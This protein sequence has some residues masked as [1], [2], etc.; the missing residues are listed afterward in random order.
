MSEHRL[1]GEVS[2]ALSHFMLI[3]L[4]AILGDT[5]RR[6]GAPMAARCHWTDEV[7]PVP[8][9]STDLT[10]DEIDETV[11]AHAVRHAG[12]D[13]WVQAVTSAG[14]RCGSALFSPRAKVPL[15]H[16][17]SDYVRER[18]HFLDSHPVNQLDR[19]LL[20]GLGEP[21]WWRCDERSATP[22]GGASRWEMKTRN[23]GEEFVLNRLAPLAHVVSERA[24]GSI[25]AGLVGHTERDEHGS[26]STGSRS[27]TGLR[28]P[29]PTDNAVAW[30][31]LWGLSVVPT[32]HQ[33]DQDTANRGYSQSPGVWPRNRVHPDQ[34]ALP[35]FTSPVSVSRLRSI[36]VTAV[37][38]EVA[39]AGVTDPASSSPS[40]GAARRQLQQ[41]GVRAVVRFPVRQTGSASAPERQL[42]TGSLEVL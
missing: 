36:L 30:C 37:F 38:D 7:T 19:R 18:T 4:S 3:G 40:A 21:A 12:P 31:A 28:T 20:A 8:V 13:S 27:A 6:V 22:D 26:D 9:L 33:A 41:W 42:L 24:A 5:D 14:S 2:S 1:A 11:R 16:E 23:R 34:H 25:W 17:W 10:A 29:G 15:L 39:F 32:I 35:V